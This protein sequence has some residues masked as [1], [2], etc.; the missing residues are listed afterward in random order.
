MQGTSTALRYQVFEYSAVKPH[1]PEKLIEFMSK[2][3][4]IVE[5][6]EK[7]FYHLKFQ[8]RHILF[9]DSPDRYGLRVGPEEGQIAEFFYEK[10][11]YYLRP[12]CFVD[13]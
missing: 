5:L 1:V 2:G 6:D 4:E 7:L 10:D 13:N 12:A 8:F 9:F 11:H 3:Q